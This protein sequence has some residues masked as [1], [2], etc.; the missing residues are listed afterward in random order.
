MGHGLPANRIFR[1]LLYNE[2]SQCLIAAFQQRLDDERWSEDLYYRH[3]S[4]AEYRQIPGSSEAIHY[5]DVVSPANMPLVL[6]N[7][8][9]WN[10][11]GGDWVSL[12]SFNLRTSELRTEVTEAS[13]REPELER[14]WVSSLI[15]VR[16]DA[17][18]VFC[19]VA[20]QQRSI[21]RGSKVHYWL[22]EMRLDDL[23]LTRI[24]SLP[25]TFA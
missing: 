11:R 16:D 7:V 19:T 12:S 14:V 1:G 21:P 20:F 8:T 3:K 5:S 10:E 17:S 25:D 2:P 13:F 15:S 9:R 24:A 4:S 22:C 6:F 18:A 23:S